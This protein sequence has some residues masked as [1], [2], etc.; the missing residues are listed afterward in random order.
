MAQVNDVVFW[1]NERFDATSEKTSCTGNFVGVEGEVFYLYSKDQNA[2]YYIDAK[3]EG[4]WHQL[5][6]G[7]L[8]AGTLQVVDVDFYIPEARVRI[9]LAAAPSEVTARAYGYPAAYSRRD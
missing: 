6:T 3:I 7:A 9:K 2:T 4:T 5:A 8:T 1:S